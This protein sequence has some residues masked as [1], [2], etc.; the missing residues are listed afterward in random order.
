MAFQ[1]D[2]ELLNQTVQA[3]ADSAPPDWRVITFYFEFLEDEQLGLRNKCTARALGG[4]NFD[5]HLDSYDL[6]NTIQTYD[7]VKAL[8]QEAVQHGE[9]WTGVRLTVLWNGRFRF[10]FFYGQT[11][12]LGGDRETVLQIMSEGLNE[13]CKPDIGRIVNPE[14]TPTVDEI[15]QQIKSHHLFKVIRGEEGVF[16]TPS[17]INADLLPTDHNELLVKAIYP[18]AEKY[19]VKFAER[20]LDLALR[21]AAS[22]ALGVFCAIQC[23]YMQVVNE[24]DGLSNIRLNRADLPQY[25]TARYFA[26][27][28]DLKKLNLS[29]NDAP[30]YAQKSALSYLRILVEQYGVKATA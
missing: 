14:M 4:E 11:P 27:V 29:G 28:E 7:T 3:L 22:D 24:E 21:V 6:G 2:P 1:A 9:K 16:R 13:L 23:Y 8:Y 10:R 20:E 12:L 15:Y 5:I 19:N 18:I 26:L 25:L 17:Y 30:D